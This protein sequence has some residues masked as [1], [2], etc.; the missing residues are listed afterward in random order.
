MQKLIIIIFFSIIC[1]NQSYA[2]TLIQALSK[3]YKDNS[4]LNAEREN[5][6]ISKEEINEAKSDFL[7]SVTISGYV[8]NEN[9]TKLTNRSGADVQS[10]DVEP[11]QESILIEQTLF[12]GL[13]GVAN[14][15]K[16]NIGLELSKLRLKKVEQEILFEAIEAYTNLVISKKKVGINILNVNLL[17]RQV[18]ND[19]NRLERSEINLT[20]LA[21][22]EASLAGANAKLIETQNQ[23]ITSKLDY[24]KTIGIINNY[25]DLR[26]TYVFN[27]ELP[28]SLASANQIAKKENPDLNIA[29]LELKQSQQDVL[30]AQSELSPSASLSYKITQTDDTSSS[31]DETDKEIL[32]AE[33]SWPIFSGGKNIASLKKSKSFRQQKQLLLEDSK[34]SNKASVANAWSNFQSSKSFLTSIRSQVKAAEIANEGITIE[35]ESGSGGRSTLDVIQSNSILLDAKINLVSS[36]RDFLLSQFK[37]L[38]SIGRLTGSYL[39]LN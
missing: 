22:S 38:A 5:L 26:E 19:K 35:Y 27:Y 10:T 30:I 2:T 34:K 24:E 21:Q 20:D 4:K 28:R 29:I 37:L 8:S 39:R 13:G 31:Y 3:A 6:E 23:L 17:E 9:T 33:A 12:Q 14:L 36:K 18:E 15:E 25:E 16:N 32:K 11:S 1:L 7:P